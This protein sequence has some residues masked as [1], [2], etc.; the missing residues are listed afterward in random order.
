MSIGHNS[1]VGRP[2]QV[3]F[4]EH[5]KCRPTS[6]TSLPRSLLRPVLLLARAPHASLAFPRAPSRSRCAP[7]LQTVVVATAFTCTRFTDALPRLLD[8]RHK[9]G[10]S[11]PGLRLAK[12]TG[13]WSI[14]SDAFPVICAGLRLSEM[15]VWSSPHPRAAVAP[16][17]SRRQVIAQAAADKGSSS[18]LDV[19]KEDYRIGGTLLGVSALLGPVFH[20][21]WPQFFLHALLGTFLT[22]QTFRVRFRFS[23]KDLDVVFLPLPWEEDYGKVT[24]ASSLSTASSGDNKLQG[25]GENKWSFKSVT[26]W[27]FWWPGFPVLVYFKENQTRPEG[28]PH[29]FPI[30]MN[31]KELYET[32]L[33]KVRQSSSPASLGTGEPSRSGE[34]HRRRAHE[35]V[36]EICLERSTTGSVAADQLLRAHRCP[37]Q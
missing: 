32:M 7:T 21:W 28:Q 27:E 25:G 18:S 9:Q 1:S 19:I 22:I 13:E 2:S 15:C 23:D 24:D 35:L 12:S 8:Q 10:A 33:K 4:C 34:L 16:G 5:T 14:R 31:G 26:N 6:P 3:K 17:S 37:N 30:I 20:L 36:T 11:E 29:F